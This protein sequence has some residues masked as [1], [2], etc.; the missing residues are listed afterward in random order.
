MIELQPSINAECF[1]RRSRRSLI[2]I[3]RWQVA[4]SAV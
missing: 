1:C 2:P 3:M 4:Y